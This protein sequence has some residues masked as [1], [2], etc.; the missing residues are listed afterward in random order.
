MSSCQ[1]EITRRKVPALVRGYAADPTTVSA[2][3]S[4]RLRR[5]AISL[6]C[7][8]LSSAPLLSIERSIDKGKEG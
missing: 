8:D 1:A 3:A 5:E 6:V 2:F 4:V 7:G